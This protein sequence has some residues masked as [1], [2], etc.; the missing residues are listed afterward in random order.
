MSHGPK[1]GSPV[2][3]KMKKNEEHFMVTVNGSSDL[4]ARLQDPSNVYV[5]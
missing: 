1:A 3:L 4:H 2:S 5:P